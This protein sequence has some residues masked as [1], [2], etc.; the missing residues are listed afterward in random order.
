M[1]IAASG[2]L[3][4]MPRKLG[5]TAKVGVSVIVLIWE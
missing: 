5:R 1:Q 2:S 3:F 4:A